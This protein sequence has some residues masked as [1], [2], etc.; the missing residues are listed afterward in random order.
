MGK[1]RVKKWLRERERVKSEEKR[2]DGV[3]QGE[4]RLRIPSTELTTFPGDVSPARV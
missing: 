1:N 4:K 2:E 3:I